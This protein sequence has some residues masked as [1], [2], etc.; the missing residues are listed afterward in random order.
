[1]YDV[2]IATLV[3]QALCAAAAHNAYWT[4]GYPWRH[5]GR[6]WS[7]VAALIAGSTALWLWVL[8]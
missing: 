5:S 7:G 1:M 4:A 3:L 8:S 6:V 2:I